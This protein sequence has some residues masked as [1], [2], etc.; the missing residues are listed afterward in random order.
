MIRVVIGDDAPMMRELIADL[1]EASGEI[2]VVAVAGDERS[3]LERVAETLP[4]VV[5]TDVRMP[6]TATDEGVRVAERLRDEH[7]QLGVVVLTQYADAVLHARV[8]AGD[9]TRRAW[10]RKER[11]NH[12]RQL[13]A[14]VKAVHAGATWIDPNAAADPR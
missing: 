12:D 6:P 9:A 2:E 4:D 1:L 13:V 14:A 5:V 3:L 7:P 8:F 11:V 10:V